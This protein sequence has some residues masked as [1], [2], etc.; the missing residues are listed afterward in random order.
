MAWHGPLLE[1]DPLKTTRPLDLKNM[2]MNYEANVHECSQRVIY[3]MY[4]F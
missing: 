2:D 3:N 4:N 1:G